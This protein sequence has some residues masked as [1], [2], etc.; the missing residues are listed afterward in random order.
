MNYCI[1][2]VETK[3]IDVDFQKLYD[4]ISEEDHTNDP[5]FITEDFGDN[6][7]YYLWNALRINIKSSDIIEIDEDNKNVLD[8]IGSDFEEWVITNKLK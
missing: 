8:K 5:K 6:A 1:T 2:T 3:D 7:L 4:Y